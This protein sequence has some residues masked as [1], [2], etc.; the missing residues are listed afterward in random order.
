[1]VFLIVWSC[2]RDEDEILPIEEPEPEPVTIVGYDGVDE[3]LWPYF[4]DFEK[5]AE[6]RGINVN[7][8]R[9]RISGEIARLHDDGVAGECSYS[10]FFPNE[11]TIDTEFWNNASD[12][13]REFVVFHE[14]GHC[15]LGREHRE[16]AF[17]NGI[18]R[19]IMRSGLG[20]CFDNYRTSTR[21]TYLNELFDESFFNEIN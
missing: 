8:R 10:S 7:L 14:L 9:E 11:V 5:E 3:A 4:A 13:A 6:L 12:R 20:D 19:S 17:S 18:C 2:A 21:T 15:S 1:M 16:A